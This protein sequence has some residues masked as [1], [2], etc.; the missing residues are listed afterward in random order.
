[1]IKDIFLPAKERFKHPFFWLFS[2]I[3]ILLTLPMLYIHEFKMD[4]YDPG[5]LLPRDSWFGAFFW[6][7][8]IILI[9]MYLCTSL[10]IYIKNK[11][12]AG[13]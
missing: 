7:W 13:T 5:Q 11:Q 2:I 10:Y 6:I 4:S 9:L 12:R 3:L 1:M 8:A